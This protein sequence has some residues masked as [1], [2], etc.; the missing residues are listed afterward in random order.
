VDEQAAAV[1]RSG[2]VGK[3]SSEAFVRALAKLRR[4]RPDPTLA[5]ISLH[6]GW[7]L[8]TSS[9]REVSDL[10]PARSSFA[11]STGSSRSLA[12]CNWRTIAAW[13]GP[14]RKAWPRTET[15]V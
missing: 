1:I 2:L 13:T 14:N 11:V 6:L 12:A 10:A 4:N 9:T 5:M 8:N 15:E 7:L 3:V